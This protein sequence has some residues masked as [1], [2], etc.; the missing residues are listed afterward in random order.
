MVGALLSPLFSDITPSDEVVQQCVDTAIKGVDPDTSNSSFLS[1]AFKECT[2]SNTV[3]AATI[4]FGVVLIAFAIAIGV[5]FRSASN[6]DRKRE[7]KLA[8]RKL[9]YIIF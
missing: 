6:A 5:F 2:E 3:T 4:S 9:R 1:M 7:E 8:A